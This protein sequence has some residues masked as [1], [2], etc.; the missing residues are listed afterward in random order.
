MQWRLSEVFKAGINQHA[1]A[2]ELFKANFYPKATTFETLKRKIN[3]VRSEKKFFDLDDP[4]SWYCMFRGWLNV[5]SFD[6]TGANTDEE[7]VEWIFRQKMK[8]GDLVEI[9]IELKEGA[10]PVVPIEIRERY[11]GVG[12]RVNSPI[13]VTK[14][15]NHR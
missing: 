5:S 2:E 10:I 12:K 14:H 13:E 3:V 15:D 8:C 9:N 1:F 6:L 11:I 4:I 7:A